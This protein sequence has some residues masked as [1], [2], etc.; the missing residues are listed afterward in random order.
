MSLE[1]ARDSALLAVEVYNKPAIKFKSG[2]YICLMM[3]AW[4]ALFHAAFFRRKIKPFYKKESGRYVKV[5]GDNRTWELDECLRQHFKTDTGN[6]IRKNLEFFIPLRNQIEHRSMPELDAGIFGECQ[7]MLLNF[8]EMLEKE[9]GGKYCLRESLS[10]SLQ[11]FPSSETLSDAVKHN[12]ASKPVLDFIQR[13]RS[14]ISPDILASGK[15]SFKA[16][17]I[18]VANHKSEKALPI[19]FVHYDKL[20]EDE[21]KQISHLVAMVKFKE[22]PVSNLNVMKASEVAK[23][24]QQALGNPK[25]QRGNKEVDRFNVS[26]HSICWKK[27]GA[28]PSPGASNPEKTDYRYCIYDRMHNDYGYTQAWIDFLAEKLRDENELESLYKWPPASV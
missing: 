8:D 23:K 9:F 7:A 18:Q 5:E 15:Y 26:V 20:S 4:T 14:T 19:Q 2:G 12:P 21:K 24:V 16:F 28:R 17:L 25:I 13:Y 11:L 22:V 1:K 3:I 6:A 27:Y 10:F